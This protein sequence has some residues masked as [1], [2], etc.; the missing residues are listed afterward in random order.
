MD[1]KKSDPIFMP[2]KELPLWLGIMIRTGQIIALII[3]ILAIG[4]I[5]Y[6]FIDGVFIN[7]PKNE[8]WGDCNT[9]DCSGLGEY[10]N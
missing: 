7:P 6:S 2:I 5:A 9:G 1:K 10:P 3:S 8:T 4:F